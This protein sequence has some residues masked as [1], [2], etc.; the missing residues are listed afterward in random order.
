MIAPPT[1]AGAGGACKDGTSSAFSIPRR[2]CMCSNASATCT[3]RG[4]AVVTNVEERSR[5][6]TPAD[7]LVVS[8]LHVFVYSQEEQCSLDADTLFRLPR[9]GTRKRHYY[10]RMSLLFGHR[11]PPHQ[12]QVGRCSKRSRQWVPPYLEQLQGKWAQCHHLRVADKHLF[13]LVWLLLHELLHVRYNVP[14]L[15]GRHL[16]HDS[17]YRPLL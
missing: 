17:F 10:G 11:Y 7:R 8:A 12:N 16:H 13:R 6:P 5:Q 1:T 4:K 3:K 14:N 2:T 9:A 15:V